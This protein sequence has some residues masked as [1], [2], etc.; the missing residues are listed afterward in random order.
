MLTPTVVK[1]LKISKVFYERTN[2]PNCID[3]VDGKHIRIINPEYSVSNYFCYKKFFSIALMAIADANY[4]FTVIDIGSYGREEDT[5]V[6]KQF[7]FG[8]QLYNSSLNLPDSTCLP[9]T[10]KPALP[11]VLIGDEAF[12]IHPNLLRPYSSRDENHS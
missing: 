7:A 6:F 10:N 1:W 9:N 2:F 4:C 5:N 8:K 3:A 12:R 11:Y